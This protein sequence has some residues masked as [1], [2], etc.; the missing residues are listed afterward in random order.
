MLFRSENHNFLWFENAIYP[1][2]STMAPSYFELIGLDELGS[3]DIDKL[4]VYGEKWETLNESDKAKIPNINS[5]NNNT[6]NY[7]ISKERGK[8]YLQITIPAIRRINNNFEKL[9]SFSI[10]ISKKNTSQK[11][12]SNKSISKTSSVLGTGKWI[13]L[14]VEN[15]GVHKV[16]YSELQNSGL[17]NLSNISV[18]GNG[19][20]K[21]PDRKS[22]V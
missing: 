12:I 9:V 10:S 3:V 16:T 15:S 7:S 20:K 13:K 22:V 14:S 11:N 4:T 2:P 21:L 17:T 1:D 18:W 6:T 19:G 5:L 8:S